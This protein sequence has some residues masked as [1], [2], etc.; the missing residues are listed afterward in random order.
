[1]IKWPTHNST[2]FAVG[3]LGALVITPAASK[4]LVKM[5]HGRVV[6]EPCND[7]GADRAAAPGECGR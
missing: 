4:T 2:Y 6:S 5:T 1:M 3:R 7:N